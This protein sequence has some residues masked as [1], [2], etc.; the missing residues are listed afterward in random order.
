MKL[1]N[2]IFSFGFLH[3]FEGSVDWLPDWECPPWFENAHGR[4]SVVE[5]FHYAGGGKEEEKLSD[6][7]NKCGKHVA[8]YNLFYWNGRPIAVYRKSSYINEVPP[9]RT[10]AFL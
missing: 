6:H 2:V 3:E 5:K 8:N 1:L 10:D 7:L 9:E 4:K